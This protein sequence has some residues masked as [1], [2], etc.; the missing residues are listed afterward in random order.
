MILVPVKNLKN[1]KQRL[2]PMLGPEER[3]LLA[4]A[5]L[6]DVLDTLASWA[7]GPEVAVVTSDPFAREMARQLQ[8]EV[9]PDEAKKALEAN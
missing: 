9:I 8:L 4:Q 6:Q 1:A 3:L 7:G 2:T 5:M